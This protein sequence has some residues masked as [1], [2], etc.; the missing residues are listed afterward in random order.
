[1]TNGSRAGYFVVSLCYQVFTLS[2]GALRMLILLHL[3]Q[4]GQTPWALA[5]LLLPYE[6]AGVFTN[7]LG[8]WLGA[9]LGQ[10]LVLLAG[11]LL[12]IVACLLL[13]ADTAWLTLPYVMTTQVLS[14]IAK[15]LTK[16]AAKSYVRILAPNAGASA[17]FG[18]VAVM[19]GS[20]NASKGL[21]FFVGGALLAWAGF[22]AT[23]VCLAGLLLLLLLAAVRW[24]PRT[25]QP[26]RPSI[27]SLFAH[28][29]AV[30]WLALARLFLF[31]SRDAW[32]A[33]ALPLFLV[34]AWGWGSAGVGAFLSAWVIGYGIVQ[35]AAP[36]LLRTRE[37]RAGTQRAALATFLLLLPLALTYWALGAQRGAPWIIVGLFT[38]GAVFALCSSLHSWL[39]VAMAG[40]QNVAERV[41]FYYA[42][43]AAGRLVGTLLSGW[44]FG[45]ATSHSDG[46]S[47]TVGASAVAALLAGLTLLPAARAPRPA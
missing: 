15:D 21:G 22:A 10:K 6:V 33:V 27:T 46:L 18:P 26:Q 5:L 43:N 36:A 11:L 4:T 2:D 13:A 40:A 35:A 30:N 19:T 28:D 37:L 9:R 25:R 29:R 23:N 16:T 17:L 39:V 14:G 7:L 47:A 12:Q 34:G 32:F 38:Y 1:M 45:A 44:L 42:A 31:G 8:G 20:K 3:H 41:G 24:L